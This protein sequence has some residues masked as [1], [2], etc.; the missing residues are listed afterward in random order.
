MSFH[1]ALSWVCRRSSP[2]SRSI[3]LFPH[4]SHE[5]LGCSGTGRKDLGALR[6][7]RGPRAAEALQRDSS[8]PTHSGDE[9][10]NDVG[11]VPVQ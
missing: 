7:T 9:G 10:R 2:A 5:S 1:Q 11:G 6:L 4:S 8:S 3:G